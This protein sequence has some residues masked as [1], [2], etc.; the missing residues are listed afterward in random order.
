MTG[1][2]TTMLGLP[3]Q[4][5][6]AHSSTLTAPYGFALTL[7]RTRALFFR[8]CVAVPACLTPREESG[9]EA[10]ARRQS[11]QWLHHQQEA[12]LFRS[13]PIRENG[14]QSR[15]L[16]TTPHNLSVRQLGGSLPV[17]LPWLRP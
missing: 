4:P 5:I 16:A 1:V 15:F 6:P 14:G 17:S 7:L 8:R 13:L 2:S 10:G 3:N 9:G 12:Q 11:P